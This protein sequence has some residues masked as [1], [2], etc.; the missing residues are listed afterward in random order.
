V[1]SDCSG[2]ALVSNI[3]RNVFAII[4]QVNLFVA[5]YY[6]FPGDTAEILYGQ[7]EQMGISTGTILRL[8][9]NFK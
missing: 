1:K 2:V 8:T 5:S 9:M 6:V 4:E 7:T 3:E